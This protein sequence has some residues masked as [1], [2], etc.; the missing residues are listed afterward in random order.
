MRR[1]SA[2]AGEEE[3]HFRKCFFPFPELMSKGRGLENPVK[4]LKLRHKRDANLI[5]W[6]SGQIG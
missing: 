4:L 6:N 1:T 3:R 2:F 5:A